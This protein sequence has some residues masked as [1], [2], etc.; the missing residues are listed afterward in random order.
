MSEYYDPVTDLNHLSRANRRHD[1]EHGDPG[2][3]TKLKST[4]NEAKLIRKGY[5]TDRKIRRYEKLGYYSDEYRKAR[6]E[7]MEKKK[8]KT[9]REGNWE[10]TDDG[11]MIYKP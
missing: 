10:I 8:K 9:R 5:L 4:W 7:R 2:D 11:R 1:M 3:A 6:R